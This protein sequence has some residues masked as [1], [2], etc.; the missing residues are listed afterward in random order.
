MLCGFLGRELDVKLRMKQKSRVK[1]F[2]AWSMVILWMAVIFYMSAQP[3]GV[4]N[5]M[6]KGVTKVIIQVINSIYPLDIETS[7]LQAWISRFNHNVRKLGHI[8]EYFILAI[9]VTNA[10]KRSG[11]KAFKLLFYSFLFCLAYAI[12]D[13]LHQY[14]VP[15]RGPGIGDVLR[16]S[17]GAISGIGISQAIGRLRLQKFRSY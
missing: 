5:G 2:I 15:G 9:F 11:T 3:A 7:S 8:T 6:S 17:I 4:S 10:F 12:S 16:D 1:I 14:F 13:E